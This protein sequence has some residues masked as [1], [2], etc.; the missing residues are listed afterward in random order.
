[1]YC[2]T[3]QK[4]F[5][6]NLIKCPVCGS[7]LEYNPLELELGTRLSM[8]DAIFLEKELFLDENESPNRN[9]FTSHDEALQ[10][11]R[12]QQERL[13]QER[14][15]QED[16][17]QGNNPPQ[18]NWRARHKRRKRRMMILRVVLIVLLILMLASILGLVI[19][20]VTH[21]DSKKYTAFDRSRIYYQQNF[22]YSENGAVWP[23]NLSDRCAFQYNEDHSVVVY[24]TLEQDLFVIR[25]GSVSK[26]A[27]DVDNFELA[28]NGAAL[29]YSVK[30]EE[31]LTGDLY[32]YVFGN[33][34]SQK[35]AEQVKR[36]DFV[37]AMDGSGVAY[38]GDYS[39]QTATMYLYESGKK[40]EQI[41]FEAFPVALSEECSTLF[42]VDEENS[43]CVY[44]K[45]ESIPIAQHVDNHFIVNRT[46]NEIL[47]CTDSSMMIYQGNKVTILYEGYYQLGRFTTYTPL[48]FA[49]RLPVSG[50]HYRN[51][52]YVNG[53]EH[54][55]SSIFM[56]NGNV[57]R[58]GNQ[59][60]KA[61][62]IA[63]SVQDVG[64]S[65]QFDELIAWK[66]DVLQKYGELSGIISKENL[67]IGEEIEQII[68]GDRLNTF[69]VWTTDHKLLEYQKQ[70]KN[71]DYEVD[72]AV[73]SSK[74]NTLVYLKKQQLYQ[75]HEGT[76]E[77]T[78]IEGV[79]DFGLL[80]DKIWYCVKQ[81][82]LFYYYL[83][84]FEKSKELMTLRFQTDLTYDHY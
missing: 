35:I 57:Y 65:E 42:F 19:Y 62:C 66:N 63:K 55:T 64:V 36:S 83:Y 44:K 79:L 17:H 11:E 47:F 49:K 22:F 6:Q 40:S 37:V 81:D 39:E 7:D 74:H 61:T 15:Q 70:G 8:D 43:L 33:Q 1:M 26:I 59:G 32:W 29:A 20:F 38:V 13:Q 27:S 56:T 28:Y 53:S 25:N 84:D 77:S 76:S 60:G 4:D 5:R 82:D 30:G 78:G 69:F 50:K 72:K 67:D 48:D 73:Y 80:G 12:L 10:Q 18:R 3:C 54:L 46:G 75:Y 2:R 51:Y 21:K 71:I 9:R 41:E 14:S 58:I 16:L 24:L 31:L 45:N 68:V 52:C 34:K 23:V